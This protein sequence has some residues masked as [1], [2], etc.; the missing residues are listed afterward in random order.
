MDKIVRTAELTN[1]LGLSR[2]TIWRLESRGHFPKR[3]R[4]TNRAVG[5][6]HADIMQWL[7]S[8]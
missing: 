2:T 3:L 5:W 4:L 1:I 7:A 8:K 6:R